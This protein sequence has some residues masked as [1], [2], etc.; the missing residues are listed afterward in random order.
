MAV[1]INTAFSSTL[2]DML[3]E[4]KL[5]AMIAEAGFDAIEL[6]LDQLTCPDSPWSRV[7]HK[8]YAQR[9]KKA[10]DQHGIRF[11]LA[12]APTKFEWMTPDTNDLNIIVYPYMEQKLYSR[13]AG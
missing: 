6:S 7:G 1:S 13:Q 9:L 2:R 12:Q 4:E 8:E 10:A 5:I 11:S 3:G